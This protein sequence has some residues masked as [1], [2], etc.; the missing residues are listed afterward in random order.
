MEAFEDKELLK[1]CT[2]CK[3]LLFCFRKKH[4]QME[5]INKIK[6]LKPFWENCRLFAVLVKKLWLL[7]TL[8]A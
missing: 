2:F 6:L 1:L 4:S 3:S 8:S 7:K 5:I